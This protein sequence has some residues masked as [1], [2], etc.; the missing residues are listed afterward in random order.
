M[1]VVTTCA[2]VLAKKL[3]LGSIVALLVVGM[4]L[5][6]NSPQPLLTGHIDE[7]QAVGE[8]GVMLLMFAIGLDIQ[9][10][11]L[12]TMRRLVFGLGL[13]QYV[14]TTLA[15]LLFLLAT[16]GIT[17][18]Q[19]KSVLV[20]SLALAMSS[21][22]IALPILQERGDQHTA[23]GRTAVAID[24]FQGF[25]VIPVLALIPILGAGPAHGGETFEIKTTL[26]V[27]AAVAGVFVLGRYLL[28]WALTLTARNLTTS[29]MATSPTR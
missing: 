16:P 14:L 17:G 3:N 13:A 21:S 7:L 24:I 28:P 18:A 26:E 29:A 23:H 19:W 5:G 12:W 11:R 1:M 22:A 10:T 27:V 8:I 4:L 25:M 6:P 20:V 9:P 15:I 2:V